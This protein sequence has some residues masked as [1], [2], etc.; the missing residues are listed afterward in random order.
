MA[1][2]SSH[3][4]TV[5]SKGKGME[6]PIYR[7]TVT[8]VLLTFIGLAVAAAFPNSV[9]AVRCQEIDSTGKKSCS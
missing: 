1:S 4:S 8:V 6:K 3:H 7:A 2:V 9:E 5:L